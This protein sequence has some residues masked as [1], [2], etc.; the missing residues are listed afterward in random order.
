MFGAGRELLYIGKAADLRKRLSSYSRQ[1][2]QPS[3]RKVNLISRVAEI[4]WQRCRTEEEALIREAELIQALRPPL[5]GSFTRDVPYTYIR[6]S[7]ESK[8]LSD[9][10]RFEVIHKLETAHGRIYGAFPHLGK[11]KYTYPAVKMKAGYPA[12]L[13]VLF[14]ANADS[15]RAQFP[16]RITGRSFP[17]SFDVKIRDEIQRPL[18]DLLAG[19]SSRLLA[20]L[21]ERIRA[22]QDISDLMRRGIE[23]DVSAARQF[24]L[25]GPR[26]LRLF[27]QRHGLPAGPIS[28]EGINSRLRHELRELLGEFRISR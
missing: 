8:R 14:A 18:N 25:L 27:R 16:S 2:K 5:N 20:N 7:R 3:G 11:G 13:R 10:V 21:Q 12:L 15:H 17:L 19:R 9:V 1:E 28:E 26:A 22:S 6:V 4:Q 24:Y 23:R